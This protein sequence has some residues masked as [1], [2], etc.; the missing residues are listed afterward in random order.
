MK[1]ITNEE[2][3]NYIESNS[4]IAIGG[5]GNFN[6]CNGLIKEIKSSFINKGIPNNLHLITGISS[7][8]KY[9]EVGINIL[10]EQGLINKVS[11]CHMGL[12]K[13]MAEFMQKIEVITYP[14]G[15]YLDILNA[16]SMNKSFIISKLGL[17]SYLDE[18]LGGKTSKYI[19]IDNEDYLMYNTFKIDNTLLKGSY[20]DK[21]GNVY[22]DDNSLLDDSSQLALATY[23]YG[24]KVFVQVD[25][26]REEVIKNDMIIPNFLINYIIVLKDDLIIDSY[27]REYNEQCH[28]IAKRATSEINELDVINVGVGMP[29]VIMEYIKD[30]DITLTVESGI[31]S[32]DVYTGAFF[33]GCSFYDYRVRLN[34]MINY[35]NS[36]ILDVCFLGA[37]QI[38]K[39][40]NVNV[41]RFGKRVVGPGGFIDIVTSSKKIVFMSNMVTKDD[42]YKFVNDVDEVTFASKNA[43]DNNIE[44]LYITDKCVFKLDKDGLV[45]KEVNEGVDINRDI[46]DKMEFKPII[47][48]SL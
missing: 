8:F 24:G 45:L 21:L 17:N 2:V 5:F 31:I 23:K 32:K 7:G 27:E 28:N 1:F 16:L 10:A 37:A 35:Y 11:T 9:E 48:A 15:V 14:L 33:G 46:I 44:V 26:V 34:D 3:S 12:S 39:Y 42:G 38:D 19:S 30:R 13:K 20:C 4:S 36:G 22:I 25:E 29:E 40:G 47:R 43:L 18:R 6:T 41:S